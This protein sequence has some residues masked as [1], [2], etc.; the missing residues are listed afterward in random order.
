MRRTSTQNAEPL[1]LKEAKEE[2]KILETQAKSKENRILTL[3]GEEKIINDRIAVKEQKI[4]D[5]DKVIA[6]RSQKAENAKVSHETILSQISTLNVQKE[7]LEVAHKDRIVELEKEYTAKEKE[8]IQNLLEK[9]ALI[10]TAEKE[11]SDIKNEITQ[12]KLDL[13]TVEK[14]LE[15]QTSL[16]AT[17]TNEL[18]ILNKQFS[19]LKAKIEVKTL[20]LSEAEAKI[21]TTAEKQIAYKKLLR[22]IETETENLN[23][24]KES[25]VDAEKD[26]A[27]TKAEREAFVVEMREKMEII[28]LADSK[29]DNKIKRIEQMIKD[30]KANKFLEDKNIN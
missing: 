24:L 11:L 7:K 4:L 21:S 3:S 30:G 12:V 23:V 5:L 10:A 15:I 18:A 29:L 28:N 17:K 25:I 26:L 20:E 8:L 2:V 27:K 9:N 1:E 16:V 22:D 13:K 6:D 14:N 19:A